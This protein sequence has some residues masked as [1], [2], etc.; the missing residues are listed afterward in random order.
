MWAISSN[1]MYIDTKNDRAMR[2]QRNVRPTWKLCE[3]GIH[4]ESRNTVKTILIVVHGFDK[5]LNGRAARK[6]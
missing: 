4:F 6:S 2:Q 3:M 1:H 5:R